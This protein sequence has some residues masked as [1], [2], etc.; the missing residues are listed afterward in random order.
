VTNNTMDAKVQALLALPE[1][2][3]AMQRIDS[4]IEAVVADTI[5]I[6]EVE[7]PPFME[8][9]RAALV[10][11]M[12]RSIG[13]DGVHVDA[14]KNAVGILPAAGEHARQG[15][16]LLLA[17]H[18]DTVFPAGTD[19]KVRREGDILRAPGAGDNSSSVAA[20]L[21]VARLLLEGGFE[22]PR[23]VIFSGDAGEEGL[24]DLSGMKA[25]MKTYGQRVRHVLPVDG[26]VGAVIHAGVGSRRLRVTTHSPGGHSYG[27]FGVPSAIH[28]LGRMIAG[29]ADIEVPKRP[30]TTY[31]VGVIG[32]GTSVNTIAGEAHMLVDMRSES[33]DELARLEHKVR[34]AIDDGAKRGEVT[35]D[36]EVVGDRPAGS[37]PLESEL[38]QMILAVN[39]ALGIASYAEASSTDAN[40]PLGMGIPAVTIGIKSGGDAHR[41]TDYV[42]I[43]SFA[44]GMKAV[45]LSI[46]MAV[47][48]KDN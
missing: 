19:V 23:E 6:T 35:Y 26:G 47:G 41:A 20:M 8:D 32:G 9:E 40:V 48:Y 14:A 2:R 27:A 22:L 36:I 31:T 33:A 11:E 24:G 21:G 13:L 38:P 28:A 7:A 39:R 18:I 12:M 44:P 34:R 29:I 4:M 5:R 16:A 15:E 25:L 37:I 45:L 3:A 17:A 43:S 1:V 10:A 42:E 46:L 30:K